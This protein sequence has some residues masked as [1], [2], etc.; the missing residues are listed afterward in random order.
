MDFLPKFKQFCLFDMIRLMQMW[1]NQAHSPDE[2]DYYSTIRFL[3]FS[4][5][6]GYFILNY[7]IWS[8]R[9]KVCLKS[10]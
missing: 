5:T 9:I 6:E 10:F 8:C 2:A 1:L 4:I 3:N 7:F